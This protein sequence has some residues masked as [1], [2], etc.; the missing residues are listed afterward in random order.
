A[1]SAVDDQLW[2]AP[3]RS[4][5]LRVL[6]DEER[7]VYLNRL[8]DGFHAVL[9][10]EARFAAA[11]NAHTAENLLDLW[12]DLDE[13]VHSLVPLPACA[14]TSWWSRSKD[15]ARGVLLRAFERIR[16]RGVELE[17][18]YRVLKGPYEGVS[19]QSARDL[20]WSGPGPPGQVVACLRVYV[21][22]A[23]GPR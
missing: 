6:S 22:S 21:Q 9:A 4:S 1:L 3:A 23:R 16:A 20:R 17:L 8:A 15:A 12:I 5:V 2:H 10:A 19:A 14:E 18:A 11:A 7:T 13:I